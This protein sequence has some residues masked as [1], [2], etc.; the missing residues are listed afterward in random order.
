MAFMPGRNG[1]EEDRV[2]RD[3]DRAGLPSG[4]ES[5]SLRMIESICEHA[6]KAA[7]TLFPD[8]TFPL[9]IGLQMQ[10]VTTDSPL[11]RSVVLIQSEHRPAHGIRPDWF[12]PVKTV[13][14]PVEDASVLQRHAYDGIIEGIDCVRFAAFETSKWLTIRTDECIAAFCNA[15]HVLFRNPSIRLAF[16]SALRKSVRDAKKKRDADS[17]SNLRFDAVTDEQMR[18]IID[19]LY[20]QW[21]MKGRL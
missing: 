20:A 12:Q 8:H 14:R 5:Q 13:E 15:K 19:E 18:E 17:Q 4:I 16:H 2:L 9:P 11:S 1:F 7:R 3:F 6:G 21:S 10:A